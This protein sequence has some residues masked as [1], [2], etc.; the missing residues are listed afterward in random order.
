MPH[1]RVKYSW[2]TGIGSE[3]VYEYD[4]Y[5]AENCQEAADLCR[6]EYGHLHGM[7]VEFIWKY[8]HGSW[9]AVNA[10]R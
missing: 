1:Y 3:R 8:N 7:R 2:L 4:I 10:W 6:N 5:I 9:M